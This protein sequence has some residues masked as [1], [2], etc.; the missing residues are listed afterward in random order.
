MTVCRGCCCG[1]TALAPDVDHAGQLATLRTALAGEAV[2]RVS[3][4]L[5]LCAQANV[6]VVSPSDAGRAAGA[7]PVWLGLVT[8]PGATDDLVTWVRAGGPGV[9]DPPAAL[10]LYLITPP[11]RLRQAFDR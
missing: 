2:V 3:D 5:D 6:V 1:N 10:D 11:R 7:R 4:C 8:D 9:A